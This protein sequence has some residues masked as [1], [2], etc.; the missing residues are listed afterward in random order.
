MITIVC[1]FSRDAALR[2]AVPD[3]WQRIEEALIRME[4]SCEK[5]RYQINVVES[6]GLAGCWGRTV[7]QR[8]SS[9]FGWRKDRRVERKSFGQNGRTGGIGLG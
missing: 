9:M 3:L 7:V 6:V 1:F 4:K 8:G 5:R 2:A